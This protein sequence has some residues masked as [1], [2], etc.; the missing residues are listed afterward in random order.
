[1]KEF[2]R[3]KLFLVSKVWS[4]NLHFNDVLQACDKTLRELGTDY[5][6]LYLIH[7]PNSKVPVQ[8]TLKA[9]QQLRKDG[10]IRAIG[11]SNFSIPELHEALKIESE[12]ATNQIEMHPLLQQKNLRHYCSLRKIPITA[13]SPLAR[14][15]V[16]SN[17]TIMK[18]AAAHGKTA[19]QV[20]LRWLLQKG[21]IVIPKA[22]SREHLQQNLDVFDWKLSE[23]EIAEIDAIKNQKRVVNTL[24]PKI[25]ARLPKW[26]IKIARR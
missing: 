13:Y 19:G 17:E 4:T 25:A 16:F 18:I 8:E 1:I 22:S 2:D 7:W 20:S 5:L 14:G 10:K 21:T 3:K 11:V 26:V 6:D 24:L 23:E 15:R 12:I 9:M